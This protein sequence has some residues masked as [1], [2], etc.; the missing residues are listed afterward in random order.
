MPRDNP[1]LEDSNA[2]FEST[3]DD[4]L[5][6]TDDLDLNPNDL[7][8]WLDQDLRRSDV[9]ELSQNS[10][11]LGCCLFDD[12]ISTKAHQPEKQEQRLVHSYRTQDDESR[13]KRSHSRRKAR[14]LE[15]MES[16]ERAFESPRNGSHS[17]HSSRS[18]TSYERPA[19]VNHTDD[20]YHT[21]FSNLASSM[22]RSELSRSIVLNLGKNSQ[23]P[24]RQPAPSTL[25]SL[26]DLISGKR[27]ALT[28]GLE[29]SRNQLRTYLSR[30]N[31]N[32]AL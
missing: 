20:L 32:Q 23:L 18:S 2:I 22:K 21:A 16:S 24:L 8:E 11:E 26:G 10:L 6:L 31:F 19:P 13:T 7:S 17:S 30:I 9:D 25:C 1:L 27:T 28:A 3:S 12:D 29:Q 14:K 15:T 5:M 4:V